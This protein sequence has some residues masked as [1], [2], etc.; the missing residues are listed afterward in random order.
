LITFVENIEKMTLQGRVGAFVALGKFIK[1]PNNAPILEDWAYRAMNQNNWFT[2]ENSSNAL[3]AIADNYLNENALLA[4]TADYR[5][6]DVPAKIYSIGVIMAGNIPAVGFHD[7]LTVIISGH[8][9]AV[10]LSSQDGILM[11]FLIQKLKEFEPSLP[12]RL[13]EMMKDVD[14]LIAT[15]SDNSAR[16]FEYYFRNK[17]HIIRKNRSS[18]AILNGSE[19]KEDFLNLGYDITAYFGLGCR[20]ISKMFV[21]KDY[22]F[23]PF[24]DTIE[25]LG[26]IFYHNRYKNNYDYN[27]SI[28]LVN[29]VPHLDNGFVMLTESEQL[30]SPISVVFYENYSTETELQEKLASQS[31]KIQCIVSKDAWYPNS[32]AFGESQKPR[33]SDYAD[34]VDTMRFLLDLQ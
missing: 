24:Y 3:H 28:Y 1:D 32:L 21:P 33:L 18:I 23:S 14:A 27:K 9:C 13:V 22:N 34:G 7:L 4:W 2:L 25:E 19:T 10:K 16:Y 8:E 6:Q 26:D 11:G 5:I 20:N 12:I 30:V 15:G 31:D 17:P 29:G